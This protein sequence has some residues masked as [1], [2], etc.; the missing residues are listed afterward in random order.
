MSI[1]VLGKSYAHHLSKGGQLGD[2]PRG[3]SFRRNS[4][5]GPPFNPHTGSFG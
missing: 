4:H 3:S 2:S 1:Y 5:G